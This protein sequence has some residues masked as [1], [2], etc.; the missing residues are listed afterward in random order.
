MKKILIVILFFFGIILNT[1]AGE[2]MWLPHLLEMLNEDD[3]KKMGCKIKAKDIYNVNKGSL[4]DAIVHFGGFCTG[5]VISNKG[6]L[7]TNHHCGYNNI[8]SHS[9]LEKNLLRD[10]FWAKNTSEEIPNNGLF[11]KFIEKIEDVSKDVMKGVTST[12]N[13]SEKIALIDKN[14]QELKS[15]MKLDK[16]HEVDIKSMYAGNQY[17]AFYTVRY[18]DVRLVG[19]PPESIGKFGADTDNWVWPRHTGDFSLFRI[20]AGKNNKPA[21]Y[22]KENQPFTP[23]HSLPIAIDGIKENDFTMVFGFPGRTDLYLPSIAVRQVMEKTD[24]AK[25]KMRDATLNIMNKYMRKDENTRLK[26]AAKNASIANYWKKWIGESEGLKK[27]NA[28]EKKVSFEKEFNK[29]AANTPYNGLINKFEKYYQD[30]EESSLMRDYYSE[31]PNR[32]IELLRIMSTARSLVNTFEKSGEGD[33]LKMR[34]KMM[35]VFN[36]FYKDYSADLDKEVFVALADICKKD[37]KPVYLPAQLKEKSISELANV[38]YEKSNFTTI[39][40]MLFVLN[41]PPIDAV[42]SMKNDPALI[43]ANEWNDAIRSN[44]TATYDYNKKIIDS[45]QAIYVKA[46][47]ELFPEKNFFPDANSTL[48]LTYGKVSGF[49]PK[50][51]LAYTPFTYLSGV[52]NKGIPNDYEFHVDP[53]LIALHQTKDF[54]QYKDITGDVPVCFLGSNHTSGGNSGSPVIDARGNLVGLNFDRVWEGTMSDIN[55]DESICRNIMV[56][57]R[58]VLFII[59]KFAGAKHLVDEM[60]LVKGKK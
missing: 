10:G 27:T 33:Y 57:T 47:T 24:P 21:D 8:Q 1:S 2:G 4:K 7:L 43:L 26:Y 30:I 40:K 42:K 56:D 52:V 16:F 31:G 13:A 60:K 35:S 6:L 17:I 11:V 39:E 25:I 9:T 3:M 54:G 59:D 18:N 32:N 5:E 22:A 44:A 23:K 12:I 41:M 46:Q 50:D 45:L 29:R 38:V 36:E 28:V 55:Y 15:K 34:D 58:Y 49:K 48:R 37:M 19:T 53:K 20:Y 14:M 51:G